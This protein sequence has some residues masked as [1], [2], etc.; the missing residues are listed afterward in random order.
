M[1][2]VDESNK[3]WRDIKVEPKEKDEPNNKAESYKQ[4]PEVQV[5]KVTCEKGDEVTYLLTYL[6]PHFLPASPSL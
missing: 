6:L 5:N 3:G 1:I 4:Q 2:W